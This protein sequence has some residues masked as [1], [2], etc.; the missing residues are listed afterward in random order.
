[1]QIVKGFTLICIV[2]FLN[3]SCNSKSEKKNEST[4]N[5]SISDSVT[6]IF[7]MK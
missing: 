4:E 1:M 7:L 5:S 2:L 6:L 3:L